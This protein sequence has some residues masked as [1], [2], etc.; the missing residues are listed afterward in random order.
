MKKEKGAEPLLETVINN[1]YQKYQ[2]TDPGSL[3]NP[4]QDE[5]PKNNQDILFSNDR[6]KRQKKKILKEKKLGREGTYYLET[7]NY[8]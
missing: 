2:T 8:I 3:E 4:K 1:N 6:N 5:C 7:N